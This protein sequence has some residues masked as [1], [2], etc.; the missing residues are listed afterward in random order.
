MTD[1]LGSMPM[2]IGA[3]LSAL[4]LALLSTGRVEAQAAA[5]FCG[6][7]ET[8]HFDVEMA[9]LADELGDVMGEPVECA[10]GNPGNGDILQRTTTGLAYYRASLEMPVFTDG[11]EHWAV[12][13]TGI[14]DWT[15]PD[16]D[17]PDVTTPRDAQPVESAEW[18]AALAAAPVSRV[19]PGGV[20]VGAFPAPL[21][22]PPMA[23]DTFADLPV[24]EASAWR[25][26]DPVSSWSYTVALGMGPNDAALAQLFGSIGR[27]AYSRAAEPPE[28]CRRA[29]GEE[30]CVSTSGGS[31][32]RFFGLAV[33]GQP[34]VATHVVH[35]P[36]Q[37]A[38]WRVEWYEPGVEV[39]YGFSLAE[40]A[41]RL[42][43]EAAALDRSNELYAQDLTDA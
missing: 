9:E 26:T 15:S 30:Y 34:A 3:I 1:R 22:V 43:P 25:A 14:D 13:K 7:A 16:V 12:T 18:A 19:V 32:A 24:R 39:S 36:A 11:V 38:A 42:P 27:A 6:T 5:G 33:S 40:A 28:D 29:T 23:I 20:G 17:P 35:G 41:G 31:F 8:P 10:H 4:L 2:P 21:R 37:V